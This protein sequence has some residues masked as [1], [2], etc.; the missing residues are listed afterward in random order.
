MY[1]DEERKLR[2]YCMR[3]GNVAI[4]LGGGGHKDKAVIK[5]QEDQKL[6]EEVRKLMA[7]AECILKQLDDGDLY[8]SKD[9]TEIQGNLKNYDTE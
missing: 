8:W 2:L 9:L 3:F 4:I 1:D 5:W 6:S 7:Y